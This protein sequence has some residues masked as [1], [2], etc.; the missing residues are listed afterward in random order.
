MLGLVAPILFSPLLFLN[1]MNS[2]A[3]SLLAP[4]AFHAIHIGG[5]YSGVEQLLGRAPHGTISFS[6]GWN[7]RGWYR[8]VQGEG[9][10]ESAFGT[11]TVQYLQGKVTAKSF[12]PNVRGVE[13]LYKICVGMLG[14]KQ[15][16]LKFD[17]RRFG[18][19]KLSN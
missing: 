9:Y 11:V 3:T 6:I 7:D 18:P 5:D 8:V 13:A 19:G 10:W 16:I 2:H 12:C 4:A 1:Q 15:A 17:L 14:L